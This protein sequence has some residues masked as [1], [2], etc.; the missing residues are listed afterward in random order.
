MDT[1]RAFHKPVRYFAYASA[2]KCARQ[3]ADSET[4]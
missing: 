4:E 2:V 1:A 3:L